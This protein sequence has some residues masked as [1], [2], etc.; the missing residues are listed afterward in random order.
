MGVPPA[1][2]A[3]DIPLPA[4]PQSIEQTGLTLGFIAD[5]ALKTLYLRGQMTM[6]EISSALGLPIG[7]VTDRVMDFLKSERLVEIRGGTGLSSANYQFVIVDRGSEKAQEALARSQYVGK[8]PVPLSMYVQA[9]QRQSI[10]NL[11]VT[12]DDLVRAFAHMVIPRE[13]LAQLGPA[14]NSGKSIFLFGPPGNG[15]TTIGEVLASLMKGDV[16]LPYAVEV[17]QQVIKVY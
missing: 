15:K 2:P 8:A 5:L 10:A 1:P 9:V 7:N 16:V 6:A 12:Q 4:E 3:P 17:D 11:H 13:T 14:V